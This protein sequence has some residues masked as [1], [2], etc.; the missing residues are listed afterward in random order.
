MTRFSDFQDA[1]GSH[2]RRLC[3]SFRW[4]H[5]HRMCSDLVGS[6]VDYSI[7]VL[8]LFFL[9]MRRIDADV[10][11]TQIH[12]PYMCQVRGMIHI[13]YVGISSHR[14]AD[15]PFPTNQ[16]TTGRSLM[17]LNGRKMRLSSAPHIDAQSRPNKCSI[18]NH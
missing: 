14:T 18:R 17:I 13:M 12:V 15:L 3:M 10:P 16:A 8:A 4:V 6:S 1:S 9:G 2:M 7:P 5:M 11:T